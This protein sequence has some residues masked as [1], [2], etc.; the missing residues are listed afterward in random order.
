ME[1]VRDLVAIQST[2]T[3]ESLRFNGPASDSFRSQ[4]GAVWH[5]HNSRV[6]ADDAMG[7]LALI[8]FLKSLV[9]CCRSA[10]NA[11]RLTE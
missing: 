11:T 4:S 9:S 6:F 1:V 10:T 2:Y 5:C 8:I 7:M 3:Y